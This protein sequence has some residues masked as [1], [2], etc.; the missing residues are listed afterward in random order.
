MP[1]KG[2]EMLQDITARSPLDT[3]TTPSVQEGLSQPVS[4]GQVTRGSRLGLRTFLTTL[5]GAGGGQSVM[6]Q[7]PWGHGSP[8]RGRGHMEERRA[9]SSGKTR[10]GRKRGEGHV[11]AESP[12]LRHPVLAGQIRGEGEAGVTALPTH[13][14]VGKW[15][16]CA[17]LPPCPLGP[18][19]A[20]PAPGPGARSRHTP[21][22]K[23][24]PQLLRDTRP[25]MLDPQLP[26][27]C[28]RCNQ[29]TIWG[30]LSP[31]M[32]SL[33]AGLTLLSGEL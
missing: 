18:A 20:S 28:R 12:G 32:N 7:G 30:R 16:P 8:A 23:E 22:H 3:E 6:G 25:A 13:L 10:Q 1:K 24:G 27:P 21:L 9:V 31:G 17:R 19:S 14:S 2:L 5:P 29:P 4:R 33:V 15:W 26:H 11:G